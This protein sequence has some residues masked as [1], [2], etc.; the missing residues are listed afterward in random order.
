MVNF[1]LSL[2]KKSMR[3]VLATVINIDVAI[4][5]LQAIEP[6]ISNNQRSENSVI[7]VPYFDDVGYMRERFGG[8]VT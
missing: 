3:R 7:D 8:I 6:E 2:C 1:Y 5:R 4:T